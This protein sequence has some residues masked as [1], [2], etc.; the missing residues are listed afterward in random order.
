M[1][2]EAGTWPRPSVN[3]R[4]APGPLFSGP[5]VPLWPLCCCL[6]LHLHLHSGL[7]EM[8]REQQQP[9]MRGRGEVDGSCFHGDRTSD[10]DGNTQLNQTQYCRQA[11]PVIGAVGR[12][13]AAGATLTTW[14]GIPETGTAPL[15]G[16][17]LLVTDAQENGCEDT[18][19]RKRQNPHTPIMTH[20]TLSETGGPRSMSPSCL[21]PVS[22]LLVCSVNSSSNPI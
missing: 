4:G 11:W 14:G 12:T 15:W 8:E 9:V 1:L 16:R 21:Q 3:R 7:R 18:G 20:I 6:G 2:R 19:N 17:F 13:G 10:A 22:A 5:Q